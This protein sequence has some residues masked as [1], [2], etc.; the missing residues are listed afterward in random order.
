MAAK[1]TTTDKSAKI[2]LAKR[3]FFVNLLDMS[4]RLFGAILLPILIGAYIDSKQTN[5]SQ[6]F[7]IIGFLLAAVFSGLVIYSLV[8]K[9]MQETGKNV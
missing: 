8:K 7:T 6:I 3:A 5:Q 1:M 4:W 2:S 9:I